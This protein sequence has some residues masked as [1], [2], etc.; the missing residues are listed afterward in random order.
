MTDGTTD[1]STPIEEQATTED[2]I[3][4]ENKYKELQSDYT[5]K[6]QK[7]AEFEKAPATERT[8]DE[9]NLSQRVKDD[10]K[11]EL[12]KREERLLNKF[13]FDKLLTN[14]PEL[15]K[16]EKAIRDLQSVNG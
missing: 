13:A 11:D 15:R 7:L 10:M 2:S 12:D 9:E 3:N 4:R 14:Y 6:S 1:V 16:S 5:R 8:E